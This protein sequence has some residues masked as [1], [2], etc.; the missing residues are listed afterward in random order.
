[1]SDESDWEDIARVCVEHNGA[2]SIIVFEDR[3][4]SWDVLDAK[5]REA[6]NLPVNKSVLISA[7]YLESEGGSRIRLSCDADLQ[8]LVRLREIPKLSVV[9]TH[10]SAQRLAPTT[11]KQKDLIPKIISDGVD[12]KSAGVEPA[13]YGIH[14]ASGRDGNTSNNAGKKYNNPVLKIGVIGFVIAV[15]SMFVAWLFA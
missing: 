13:A 6:F 3:K 9:I 12:V 4:A 8:D 1:M 10:G 5:V 15:G 2:T 14:H 11:Y 7:F